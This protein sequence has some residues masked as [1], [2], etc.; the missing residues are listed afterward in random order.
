M[1]R[2]IAKA[3][4]LALLASACHEQP[5]T[6]PKMA[7]R[8]PEQVCRQAKEALEKLRASG[9]FEQMKPG[10]AMIPEQAWL[11]MPPDNRD[12]MAQLLGYHSACEAEEPT[13]EQ[14]VRIRSEYG[15]VMAERIVTTSADLSTF[16]DD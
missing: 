1:M 13:T 8:L 5:D 11:D 14:T 2:M 6:A 9:G 16:V 4:L 10:E 12:Q 15:R 3:T 7:S